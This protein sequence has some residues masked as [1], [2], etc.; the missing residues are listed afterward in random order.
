MRLRVSRRF[1]KPSL[2]H[3]PGWLGEKSKSVTR[4]VSRPS[5]HKLSEQTVE[6][7]APTYFLTT[8]GP[9]HLYY[10]A[11]RLCHTSGTGLTSGRGEGRALA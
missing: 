1:K 2:S 4:R 5:K 3:R 7:E 8:I 11:I 6:E 9:R 10:G